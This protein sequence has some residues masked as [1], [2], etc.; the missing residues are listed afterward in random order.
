MIKKGNSIDF[1]TSSVQVK[2]NHKREVVAVILINRT[3]LKGN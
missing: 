2:S 1:D 3:I